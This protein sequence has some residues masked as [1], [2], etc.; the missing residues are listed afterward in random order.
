MKT[1]PRTGRPIEFLPPTLSWLREVETA[2]MLGAIL[3]G[4]PSATGDMGWF[5][6]GQSIYGWKWLL[7]RMDRDHDGSISKKEFTGTAE[8]FERL[9]RNHDGRLTAADFGWADN[10]PINRQMRI[11]HELFSRA[12]ADQDERVTAEEWQALFKQMAKGKDSLSRDDLHALVFPPSKRGEGMPSPLTLIK[13]MI[14]GEIGSIHEGPKVGRGAPD[15]TLPKYDNDDEKITL[16]RFQGKKP[17][18][19][20]FG[21]FT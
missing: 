16:S 2:Q 7:E 14:D 15:F 8:W 11:A 13:G 4:A 9:D 10:A 5:H 6:P 17:V 1:R 3:G 12:D 19:L 18:V 20:I 21:S